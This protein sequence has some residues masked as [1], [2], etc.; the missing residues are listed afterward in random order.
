MLEAYPSCRKTAYRTFRLHAFS[1]IIVSSDQFDR[2][3]KRAGITRYHG[4]FVALALAAALALVLPAKADQ[5]YVISGNDRYEIGH[6]DI[7][8]TITYNG[9]QTLKVER[10]GKTT[11]F[12]AQAQ[13][14]RSDGS[15]K[16]P[17]HAAFVQEMLPHGDFEDRSDLDP[18]YLTV[19]N[20]PFS[21]ELDATTL[22]D[23]VRLRGRAPFDFPAPMTGGTL[24]G[25]IQRGSVGRIDSQPAIG[26][27]FDA[28]GPMA[29][30][31]PGQQALSITGVMRM[32]GT[33]YYA[34]RGPAILLALNEKLVVSGTLH[35]KGRNSPVTIVY[36]RAIKAQSAPGSMTEADS[37]K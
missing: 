16:I 28:T 35:D 5:R 15:G 22:S 18:D 36:Q 34:L 13:Y 19:L 24:H 23:L 9:T 12:I 37:H 32:Q 31:L 27:D 26:V 1:G 3:R 10:R 33:A 11:R 14:T 7:A 2:P 25:Y 17:S 21:V 30:P 29:G 4:K 20:Q 8:S 6:A